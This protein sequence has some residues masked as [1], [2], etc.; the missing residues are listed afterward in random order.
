MFTA[1]YILEQHNYIVP[2]LEEQDIR[3][4]Q[5]TKILDYF[6]MHFVQFLFHLQN[7]YYK[8]HSRFS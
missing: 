2:Y 3:P 1:K 6:I 8:T 7:F 5:R 4:N